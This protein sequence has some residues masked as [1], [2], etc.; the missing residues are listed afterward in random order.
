MTIEG[1]TFYL[2]N[3]SAISALSVENL[4]IRD[5]AFKR[6][7]DGIDSELTVSQTNCSPEGK[8]G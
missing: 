5:N 1:N 7:D 8:P 3:T 4:T 2:N 6:A